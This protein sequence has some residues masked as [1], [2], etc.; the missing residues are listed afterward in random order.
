MTFLTIPDIMNQEKKGNQMILTRIIEMLI[1]EYEL[2]GDLFY[3]DLIDIIEA[4]IK[5]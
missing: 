4:R 1:A 2:T 5:K 3:K